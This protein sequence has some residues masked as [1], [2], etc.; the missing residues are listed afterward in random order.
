MGRGD[1]EFKASFVEGSAGS[2]ICQA[3]RGGNGWVEH[4]NKA[5]MRRAYPLDRFGSGVVWHFLFFF[6]TRGVILGNI[7]IFLHYC[8]WHSFCYVFVTSI[9]AT[10]DQF[11]I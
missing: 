4:I 3:N 8:C 2:H 6:I 1:S 7:F 9:L 5:G 10:A 11:S